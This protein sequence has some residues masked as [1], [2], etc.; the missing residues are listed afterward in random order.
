MFVSD[1]CAC[2]AHC[3]LV[4]TMQQ[5]NGNFPANLRDFAVPFHCG[6]AHTSASVFLVLVVPLN[7]YDICS[8]SLSCCHSFVA[9]YKTHLPFPSKPPRAL[10]LPPF[11][12]RS[13]SMRSSPRH[14]RW[15]PSR[16]LRQS[17]KRSISTTQPSSN[18]SVAKVVPRDNSEGGR[19]RKVLPKRR[20][21]R[22]KE[23]RWWACECSS[24]ITPCLPTGC[25][26]ST[27]CIFVGLGVVERRLRCWQQGGK[28]GSS[29]CFQRSCRRCVPLDRS[30]SSCVDCFFF[31]C[32]TY[33][34]PQFFV[35]LRC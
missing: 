24:P 32:R 11:P 18:T 9:S 28:A 33:L 12:S 8:A 35:M 1:F 30:R 13:I 27:R 16:N 29:P 4:A 2:D 26:R 31:S 3:A 23:R 22:R 10:S 14:Y 5:Y 17:S 21:C 20:A 19:F 6:V 15:R 25:Q 7:L 34:V